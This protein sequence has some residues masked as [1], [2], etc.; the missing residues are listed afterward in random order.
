MLTAALLVGAAAGFGGWY[1]SKGD[2]GGTHKDDARTKVSTAPTTP[3]VS[4]SAPTPTPTLDETSASPSESALPAG[5]RSVSTG[6]FD[7]VVPEDWEPDSENGKNGVTIYY[8]RESGGGPRYLQVFRVSEAD[9]TPRGTLTAAEADLKKRLPD[10]HR[11]SLEAVA[12]DRG[13][14]AEL[15]YTHS[16]EKWGVELRTLDRVIHADDNQLY[17]VLTAGPADAWPEQQEIQDAA[18]RS[19][20]LTGAAC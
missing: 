12:D 10:Y 7:M 19:F 20:C 9:P 6:E 1:A 4:E 8:F 2:G 14:A 3:S 11:N 16:S 15:D 5:Y 13:E 18:V 17:A